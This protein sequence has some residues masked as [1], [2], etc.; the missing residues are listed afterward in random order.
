MH[1]RLIAL[2]EVLLCSSIPTQILLGGLL[3]IG[4]YA[5]ID[6]SGQLSLSFVV[7]LSVVD[8]VVLIALMIGLTRMHGQSARQLWLGDRRVGRE[9][10]VGLL[11]IPPILVAVIVLL[12][13]M[14]LTAPW[15]HN[16]ETNPLE[17][18][19]GTPGEAALFGV[20][21]ILAGGVREE[22][23][24]AFLLRRFTDHLGGTNVGIIVLSL[25]FGLGH[26]VQGWDA[27]VTTGV[28]GFFWALVYVRRGSSVAPIVSHAGFNA[29]EILRVAIVGA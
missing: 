23:Q 5:P 10:V 22:L 20:V 18:L 19:A 26:I 2:S 29:L 14:R 21:A 28:L 11:L 7:I 3:R 4:G 9:T 8:T 6:R 1:T 24:R 17:K 27:V 25:A 16:V 13:G 15:L 12:N